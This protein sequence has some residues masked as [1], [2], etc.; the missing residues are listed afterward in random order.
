LRAWGGQ[1]T[2]HDAEELVGEVAVGRKK[3]IAGIQSSESGVHRR[4]L[5]ASRLDWLDVEKENTMA[6]LQ[7]IT[8]ELG[9][10]SSDGGRAR[11]E[12]GFAVTMKITRERERIVA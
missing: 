12:L 8:W 2:H 6:E 9:R 10:S 7:S 1:E 4:R 11:P 5:G 3:E